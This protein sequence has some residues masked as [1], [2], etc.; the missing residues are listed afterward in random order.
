MQEIEKVRI[1]ITPGIQPRAVSRML[2]PTSEQSVC[3]VSIT[4]SGGNSIALNDVSKLL[5]RTVLEATK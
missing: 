4:A 1:R 3:R 2:M 5:Y